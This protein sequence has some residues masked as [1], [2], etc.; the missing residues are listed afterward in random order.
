[1]YLSAPTGQ[2]IDIISPEQYTLH[3]ATVDDGGHLL[4]KL[5]EGAM[6]AKVNLRSAFRMIPVH[7]EDW[8]LL[9]MQWRGL[10]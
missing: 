2:S 8:Q 1:M 7:R 4:T 6:L 3:Y 5:G 9:G 10:Y